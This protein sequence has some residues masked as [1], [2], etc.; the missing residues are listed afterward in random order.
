[1]EG[2]CGEQA[3]DALW[4]GRGGQRQPVVL[5][6][7]RIGQAVSPMPDTLQNSIRDEAGKGL[8]VDA[9]P[10]GL[11]CGQEPVASGECDRPLSTTSLSPPWA[12]THSLTLR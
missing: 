5:R 4:D 10:T 7:R 8:A 9:S 3:D 2:E 1:M 11:S 12:R 6:A